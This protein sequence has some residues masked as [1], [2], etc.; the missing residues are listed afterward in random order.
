[1]RLQAMSFLYRGYS[2]SMICEMMKIGVSTMRRWISAFNERGIDGLV[3]RPR[4]G[5][6]RKIQQDE[7]NSRYLPLVEAPATHGFDF[8]TAVRLHG[9]LTETLKL[10]VSYCSV[11]RYLHSAGYCR[12]T[13]GKVHPDRDEEAR[14]KFVKELQQLL[15]NSEKY[16]LWFSDECGVD[17]DPR[18]GKAW[19]RKGSKPKVQY[20][21]CHLRQSVVGAVEPLSG[22]F[23][24][25]A[26]PYT[27]ATVFQLFLD[28]LASRTKNS[29]KKILLILDNASWH[30]ASSL[31]WHHI[32]PKYLPAY[33]PDLN[34][35]ERLWLELKSKFFTNWYTR[36]PNK[37]L[38][39]VCEGLKSLIEQPA[40]IASICSLPY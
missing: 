15:N 24:A 33:S 27:D 26:V 1:M 20:D 13:P 34:P 22:N 37:L 9:H 6:P 11:V 18:T 8:M 19:F 30:H 35:I 28:A 3:S 17:G 14:T 25:M 23:E 2:R 12:K 31:N 7:F 16:E 40:R 5:R 21:G 38:Q 4:S 39:R 36:D 29:D 10:E 32:E